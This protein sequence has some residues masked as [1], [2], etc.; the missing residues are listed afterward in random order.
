MRCFGLQHLRRAARVAV[1]AVM[2]AGAAV[3][4]AQPAPP[5]ASAAP[6]SAAAPWASLPLRREEAGRDAA[7]SAGLAVVLSLIALTAAGA[8][9][10]LRRGR[11]PVSDAGSLRRMA[12]LALPPQTAVHVIRWG[13]EDLLVG[14]AAQQFTL[15]ARR[16]SASGDA[17]GTAA[18]AARADTP[19]TDA[20]DAAAAADAASAWRPARAARPAPEGAP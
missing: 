19:G 6:A 14:V 17:G 13:Q 18:A 4:T 7:P 12:T 2:L 3:A 11:R 10:Y 8:W 15:L 20:A 16:P 9:L 1:G 5:A